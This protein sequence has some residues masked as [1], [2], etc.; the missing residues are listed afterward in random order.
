MLEYVITWIIAGAVSRL[1]VLR[2]TSDP[3]W[4]V[5]EVASRRALR[6][7]LYIEAPETWSEWP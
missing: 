6:A 5:H 4:F 2:D 3:Q 7:I 1:P